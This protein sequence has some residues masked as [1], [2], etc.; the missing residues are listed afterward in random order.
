MLLPS[1]LRLLLLPLLVAAAP[2]APGCPAPDAR[3]PDP[4]LP[5]TGT[6]QSPRPLPY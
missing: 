1:S 6:G 2:A 5:R 4:V 3:G